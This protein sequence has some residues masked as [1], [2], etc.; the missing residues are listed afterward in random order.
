M[1]DDDAAEIVDELAFLA[2]PHR[3][4]PPARH[5]ESHR[6]LVRFRRAEILRRIDA[7]ATRDELVALLPMDMQQLKFEIR[8]AKREAGRA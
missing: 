1:I 2:M 6:D 4:G 8:E 7:G 3:D 5:A